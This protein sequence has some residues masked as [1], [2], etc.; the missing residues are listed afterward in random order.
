MSITRKK[1]TPEFK[2]SIVKAAVET[3]NASLL[4]GNMD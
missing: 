4:Q 1:Y 2:E 3:G